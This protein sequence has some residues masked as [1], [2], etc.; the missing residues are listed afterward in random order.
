MIGF[1][2]ITLF[3]A[4]IF[5]FAVVLTHSGYTMAQQSTSVF[6]S[7]E[8]FEADKC[9]SIWLIKRFIH[10]NAIFKFYPRSEFAM[11]GIPFDTPD[12]KFRRYHNMSTF[13]SI[14]QH[15]GLQD[16]VL[17]YIGRIMHDIEVNI[18][19]R[20]IMPETVKVQND[21]NSIIV[22]HKGTGEIIGK[23]CSYFDSL[24]REI[25]AH[26]KKP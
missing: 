7:W 6:S 24:Y 2:Y 12:A 15:Y 8:G 13:E 9:A 11:E 19:E 23:S 18:W 21:L 22:T 3:S 4:V 5:A 14:L 17:V 10:K 20:K 1:R 25:K 16:P 26:N